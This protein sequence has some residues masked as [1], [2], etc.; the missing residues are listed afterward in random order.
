M[1]GNVA[2][3]IFENERDDGEVWFNTRFQ[4]KYYRDEKWHSAESFSRHDLSD[5]RVAA[6]EAYAFIASETAVDSQVDEEGYD[7][8]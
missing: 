7:D 5:V 6:D 8:E 3:K 2:V 1:I 4:R